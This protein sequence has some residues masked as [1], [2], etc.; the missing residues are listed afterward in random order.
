MAVASAAEPHQSLFFL[1]PSSVFAK[2]LFLSVCL[3][4]CRRSSVVML[5]YLLPAFA[6]CHQT[7]SDR[8][9]NEIAHG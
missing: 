7:K 1:Q 5:L 2:F 3:S 9:D 8:A 4:V 6:P